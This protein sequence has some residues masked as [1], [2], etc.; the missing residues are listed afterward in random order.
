MF[1]IGEV[2]G[3]MMHCPLFG[4]HAHDVPHCVAAAGVVKRSV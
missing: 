2:M 1:V 4:T 3:L